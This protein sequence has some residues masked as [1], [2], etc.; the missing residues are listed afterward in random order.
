M[1]IK[2]SP[3]SHATTSRPRLSW[4]TT[5]ITAAL[6]VLLS[7]AHLNAN[8]LALGALT[9]LSSLGEPFAAGIAI[10]EITPEEFSSLKITLGSPEAFKN[11]GM[12][13]NPAL[14]SVQIS[15][16][17]RPDGTS[18]V[19]LRSDKAVTDPFVNLV[20]NATWA[21][22]RIARNYT[23]L[24]DPPATRTSEAPAITAPIA[25]LPAPRPVAPAPAP[26]VAAAPATTPAATPTPAPAAANNALAPAPVAATPA[27]TPTQAV[28]AKAPAKN[29]GEQVKVSSGD[30]AGKI[31]ANNKPAN[32]SLDQM[33]VAMLRGNPDAFI[34]NNV[35]RIK[36]G[37]ILALPSEEE[38]KAVSE[39]AARQ[40]VIAQSKD[41]NNFRRKLA[42]NAPSVASK[43]PDR[44][45]GG[46]VEAKVEDRKTAVATPDKLTLSK[47]A[48]NADAKAGG[49]KDNSEKIAKER[50]AKDDAARV[51][52]LSKNISDLNK[53]A[54]V[55]A[56]AT[57][58]K[59]ATPGA[60][61]TPAVTATPSTT[62][63][64]SVA[65]TAPAAL[66]AASAPSSPAA[67]ATAT[68]TT[69]SKATT[70]GAAPATMPAAGTPGVAS[71][72][73]TPADTTAA[74]TPAKPVVKAPAAPVPE[75][76]FIDELMDNPAVLPGAAGLLALLAAGGLYVAKKRKE[77]AEQED[78]Q[79]GDFEDHSF[80]DTTNHH[81]AVVKTE[82]PAIQAAE[83]PEPVAAVEPTFTLPAMP[84]AAVLPVQVEA[85]PAAPVAAAV[86]QAAQAAP[87]EDNF[88]AF[89]PS[90]FSARTVAQ[91]HPDTAKAPA[92]VDLDL[93][94]D[95][96]VSGFHNA[97][98]AAAA[99]PA[100][101]T[102]DLSL[103]FD[104]PAAAPVVSAV[105][106]AP[107]VQAAASKT[108]PETALAFATPVVAAAA[109]A[110]APLAFD[111][112]NLSLDLNAA[113]VP[114]TAKS[115][116][117]A[118]PLETK[119]ALAQEFRAIGDAAGAKMLAQEVIALATGSLKTKAENLL[120]EIG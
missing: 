115:G 21:N 75:P 101:A 9:S 48:L 30:T 36:A 74:A 118:G 31:A 92:S 60:T 113:K 68:P 107:V 96:A 18:Y 76:S 88:P 77:R 86:V 23:L 54:G 59:P 37:A 8:A 13:Y 6:G 103:D 39:S 17:R 7:T 110:A 62:T 105:A 111:L 61:T 98:P 35:N 73:A 15:V 42:E 82:E 64:G 55:A 116:N 56:T 11:A 91:L 72:P 94:F 26:V 25:T 87:A 63:A 67:P 79:D 10:P 32:V 40:S 85:T 20:I 102:T 109:V 99:M 53:V 117:A 80:F 97:T 51:A 71:T 78:D 33:L 95:F 58:A 19:L 100:P 108:S 3:T 69:P 65:V 114:D 84:A 70:A 2:S 29:S 41:F 57:P 104:M 50:Q 81:D 28:A 106:A 49:T 12:E 38:A 112:D 89:T 1:Q 44:Q 83:V 43:T 24:L 93:D 45:A 22:G 46:K 34:G 119:L 47:G 120:A 4:R 14:S 5:A 66:A 90:E 16:N 52:E 27:A